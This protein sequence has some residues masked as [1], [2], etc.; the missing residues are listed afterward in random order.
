[1]DWCK[2]WQMQLNINKCVVLRYSYMVIFPVIFDYVIDG[3]VITGTDQHT[4]LG[5][6]LHKTMQW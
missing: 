6:I 5:I 3:K 4:Y 2:T 1:M